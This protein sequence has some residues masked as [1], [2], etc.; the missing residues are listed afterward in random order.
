MHT[1]RR[2][3]NGRRES[4]KRREE[5]EKIRGVKGRIRTTLNGAYTFIVLY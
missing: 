5:A 3:R 4:S 1:Q 2:E